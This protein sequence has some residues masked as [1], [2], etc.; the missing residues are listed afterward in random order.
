[1][2]RYLLDTNHA[3][4]FWRRREAVTPRL[5][6]APDARIGLCLPSIGELW[7]MVFRSAR[8]ESNTVELNLFLRDYEHWPYDLAAAAEFGRIKAELRQAGR[9]IPVVDAQIA[10]IARSN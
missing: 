4:L 1:M 10:A 8:V 3:S 9:P 7:Y 5:Q 2:T 6:A